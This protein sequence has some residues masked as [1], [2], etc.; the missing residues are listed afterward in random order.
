VV[1]IVALFTAL[2]VVVVAPVF[3]PVPMLLAVASAAAMMPLLRARLRL[4]LGFPLAVRDAQRVGEFQRIGKPLGHELGPG[5]KHARHEQE[6]ASRVSDHRHL[7]RA[8]PCGRPLHHLALIGPDP[9]D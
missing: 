6:H 4:V 1:V 2:V 8:G 5:A 7:E 3:A 9:A